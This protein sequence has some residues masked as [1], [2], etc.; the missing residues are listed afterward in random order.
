MDNTYL[1]G[2]LGT[3]ALI[4]FLFLALSYISQRNHPHKKSTRPEDI[5]T[6]FILD[7]IEDGVVM[8]TADGIVHLFNPAAARISGWGPQEA[9]GLNYKDVIKLVDDKGQPV[10]DA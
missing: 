6:D 10:P 5:E 7:T 4:T 3:L 9:V 2:A 1:I 8:V